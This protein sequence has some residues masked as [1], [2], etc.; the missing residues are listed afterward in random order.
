[1][2]VFRGEYTI[3][4]LVNAN[5]PPTNQYMDTYMRTYTD[6]DSK[7]FHIILYAKIRGRRTNLNHESVSQDPGKAYK[8]KLHKNESGFYCFFF[9]IE[10]FFMQV[11]VTANCI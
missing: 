7:Y 8:S 3:W 6:T 5:C 4:W 1:M 2:W 9:V 11:I 10:T